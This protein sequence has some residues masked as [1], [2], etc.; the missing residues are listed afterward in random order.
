MIGHRLE[1]FDFRVGEKTRS[2]Q[3]LA[4]HGVMRILP[5]AQGL[6]RI[7]ATAQ[8]WVEVLFGTGGFWSRLAASLKRMKHGLCSVE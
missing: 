6:L 2:I 5:C 4:W 7:H 1:L 3:G 8:L